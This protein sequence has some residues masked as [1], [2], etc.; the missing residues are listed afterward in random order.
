M[1]KMSTATALLRP[2][3]LGDRDSEW[4][5]IA[6]TVL[7][8]LAGALLRARVEGQTRALSTDG[9]SAEVP[10]RWIAAVSTDDGALLQARATSGVFP[11]T[12]RV[13]AFP[14][15]DDATLDDAFVA[16]T[17]QLGSELT[18]FNVLE[19]VGASVNGRPA[20]KISFAYVVS[21]A[22]VQRENVPA[23]VRGDEYIF[24]DGHGRALAVQFATESDSYERALPGFE[25]FLLSVSF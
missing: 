4:A 5:V 10:A 15:A 17:L 1:N 7:A 9:V 2:R 6:V 20:I 16:R 25:R 8:L 19:S 24:L 14:L 18:A 13:E 3:S 11:T 21:D 12:Y 22:N 23:S